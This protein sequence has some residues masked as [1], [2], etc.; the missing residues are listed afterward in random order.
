MVRKFWLVGLVLAG[1]AAAPAAAAVKTHGLFSDNMVLQRQLPVPIWGTADDGETITVTFQDRKATTTA[2]DGKWLV[3]LEALKEGGPFEMTIAGKSD[4]LTIKNVLVGEVWVASGQSNMQ[5]SV[6]ASADPVGVKAAATNPQIRLY[7]V[8]RRGIDTPQSD[9][10][11][12]WEVCSPDTV[13]AFSAV[14]YHFGVDLQK[15]LDMPVGLIS[16]NYGGTPAEAWTRREVL[17]KHPELKVYMQAQ[18]KALEAYPQVIK[19]W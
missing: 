19:D 11:G 10:Q 14:A 15:A 6:D 12:K 3:R 4:T 5:W 7:T 1:L 17:E 9:V 18:L 16:S 8:P 13:G 2:K